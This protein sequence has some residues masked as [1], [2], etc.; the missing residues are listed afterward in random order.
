MELEAGKIKLP[1]SIISLI[2]LGRLQ[3]ELNALADFTAQLAVREAGSQPRLPK[4]SR[5]LEELAKL[6]N[7][8]L[9]IEEERKKLESNL[10][11]LRSRAPIVHISFSSDPPNNFLSKII[12]WFRDEIDP[13]LFLQIGLQPSIA[14]GC[15]IRTPNKQFDFS[16]RR[17]FNQHRQ[18]LIDKLAQGNN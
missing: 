14:A 8:N 5:N 17:H 13:Q 1:V 18:L 4:T 2:D 10:K 9:L 7:V 12:T 6:N 11:D 3:R 16:L 15:I